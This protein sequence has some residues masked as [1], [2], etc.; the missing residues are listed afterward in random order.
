MMAPGLAPRTGFAAPTFEQ[1]QAQMEKMRK[2]F[3]AMAQKIAEQQKAAAAAYN[4]SQ[5]AV[6]ATPPAAVK[7]KQ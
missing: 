6:M 4:K 2:Q 7:S 5:G 1:K 3:E